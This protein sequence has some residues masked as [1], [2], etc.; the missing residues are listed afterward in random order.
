MRSCEIFV[1]LPNSEVELRGPQVLALARQDNNWLYSN[2]CC[3]C[4]STRVPT[5]GEVYIR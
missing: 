3:H 1:G 4:N 2:Y 5:H